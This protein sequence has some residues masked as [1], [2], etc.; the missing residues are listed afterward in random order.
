[1]VGPAKLKQETRKR[2]DKS[3]INSQVFLACLVLSR[4][5]FDMVLVICSYI[6]ITCSYCGGIIG[7][8]TSVLGVYFF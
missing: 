1:M 5:A 4:S 8:H 3:A 7:I 2:K 6:T